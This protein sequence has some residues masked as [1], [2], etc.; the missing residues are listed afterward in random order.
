[1]LSLSNLIRIYRITSWFTVAFKNN[2]KPNFEILES[3]P[4]STFRPRSLISIGFANFLLFLM[5]LLWVMV[6]ASRPF[7]ALYVVTVNKTYPLLIINKS[8]SLISLP[9]GVDFCSV[10]LK[11]HTVAKS[12]CVVFEKFIT[13]SINL[14]LRDLLFWV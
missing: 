8:Q 1:M 7:F 12:H 5:S 6:I 4:H 13:M 3:I 9:S 2:L 10:L 11:R 14:C